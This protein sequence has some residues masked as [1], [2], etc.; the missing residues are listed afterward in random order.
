MIGIEWKPIRNQIDAA[1]IFARL[2]FVSSFTRNL[3]SVFGDKVSWNKT[4]GCINKRRDNDSVIQVTNHR[5]E[6]GN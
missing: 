2:D 4:E 5:D 1:F 3:L 6:I